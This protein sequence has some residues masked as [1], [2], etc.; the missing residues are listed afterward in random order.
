MIF[1]VT[2]SLDISLTFHDWRGEKGDK[3]VFRVENIVR[4]LIRRK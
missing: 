1:V 2:P 4:R 3:W